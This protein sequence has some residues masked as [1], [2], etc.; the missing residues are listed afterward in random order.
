M[1][2]ILRYELLLN[3]AQGGWDISPKRY[4][5]DKYNMHN[6]LCCNGMLEYWHLKRF[7]LDIVVTDKPYHQ[8][9]KYICDGKWYEMKYEKEHGG[10]SGVDT[11]FS[12]NLNLYFQWEGIDIPKTFYLHI[13]Q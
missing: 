8:S 6:C 4:S 5:F 2:E 1:S 11:R 7:N 13:E 10:Y 9:Y 12:H 3:K